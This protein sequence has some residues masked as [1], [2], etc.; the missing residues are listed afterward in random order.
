MIFDV[1]ELK[2][3]DYVKA[4]IKQQSPSLVLFEII[5]RLYQIEYRQRTISSFTVPAD[6]NLSFEDDFCRYPA[7]LSVSTVN[8]QSVIL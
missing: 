2:C 4:K 1:A 7:V 6:L 8:L 3:M 5:Q